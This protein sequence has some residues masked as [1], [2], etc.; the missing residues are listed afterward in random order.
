MW[1]F[2]GMNIVLANS[3]DADQNRQCLPDTTGAADKKR[4]ADHLASALHDANL[5]LSAVK[6]TAG[7]AAT[8]GY[9][10]CPMSRRL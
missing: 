9:V 2:N 10:A 1:V 8:G 5:N 6:R 4:F 3:R 7:T